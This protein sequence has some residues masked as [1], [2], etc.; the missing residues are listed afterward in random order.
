MNRIELLPDEII[1]KIFLE[2]HKLKF[3]YCIY[4]ITFNFNERWHYPANSLI[5]EHL[6]STGM[7]DIEIK[8]YFKFIDWLDGKNLKITSEYFED[9]IYKRIYTDFF[10]SI[11][12]S[13][14]L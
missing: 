12:D 4:K 6:Y 14:T 13:D 1:E 8:N 9:N 5:T 10:V 2:A 3:K 7:T 11:W